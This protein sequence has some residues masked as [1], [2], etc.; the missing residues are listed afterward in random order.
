MANLRV[1]IVDDE[2]LAVERLAHMCGSIDAIEVVGVAEDGQT[3]LSKAEE[4]QPDV[5]LLDISMPGL[6]GMA[7]AGRLRVSRQGRPAVVFVTAH[8]GFAVEAFALAATDYLLKPV[9]PARLEQALA[10][11]AASLPAETAPRRPFLNEIWAPHGREMTRIAVE[12]LDFV[13]AER[14]YMRLYAGRA[15]YLVRMVLRDLESRLDPDRFIRVHRSTLVALDRIV[16][17]K[18]D[19]VDGWTV[20]LSSGHRVRVGRSFRSVV[21]RIASGPTAD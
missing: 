18:A 11:A 17:V 21:R 3:A 9:S 20:S 19:S 6:D 13:E 4:L 10:R 2:P 15:S 16:A 8:S 14:D 1:L 12:A 5:L 7:L